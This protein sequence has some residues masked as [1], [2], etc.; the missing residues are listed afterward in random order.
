MH[1]DRGKI[2]VSACLCGVKCRYNGKACSCNKTE[3]VKW[4]QEGRLVPVCPEVMAGLGTPR[5]PM[6]IN[7][8]RLIT[9]LGEDLTDR[10]MAG[11]EATLQIARENRVELCV[12]KQNSP[13]CGASVIYDGTFSGRRIP[14]TGI[15]AAALRKAGFKV[16]SE[17]ELK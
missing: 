12:L 10:C 7:R 4:Q 6:E 11:V 16:I 15:A 13:T 8:G 14:G 3:F 5:Y 9:Q 2:L 1:M 17:E